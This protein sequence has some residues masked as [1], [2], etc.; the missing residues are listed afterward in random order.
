MAVS[1][2]TVVMAGFKDPIADAQTCFRGV[3]DAMAHPGRI[4]PLDP[5]AEHPDGINAPALSVLLTLADYTTPIWMGREDPQIAAYLGFHSGAPLT[6]H[7]DTATFAWLPAESR[8][9]DLTMF[10]PGDAEYP[11]RAATVLIDISGFEDGPP[12]SLSGPG[13]ENEIHLAAAGLDAS[14]WAAMTANNASYPLGVDIIL[15][16]PAAIV[17][18][19]RSI[20]IEVS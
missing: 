3:L 11:D 12:V 2:T 17:A 16:G 4:V 5:P 8:P 7:A 6:P 14:F 13:I 1:E 10:H 19:P 18:I 9:I 20:T 15:T